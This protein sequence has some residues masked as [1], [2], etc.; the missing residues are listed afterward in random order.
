MKH[1]RAPKNIL[2]S[3]TNV[4]LKVT[5]QSLLL[6]CGLC[7]TGCAVARPADNAE[8]L[9][10]STMPS[11]SAHSPQMAMD[12]SQ[13]TYFKSVYGMGD[14]D[15]FMIL[16]SKAVPASS[17]RIVTGDTDGND[18]VTK[19]YVE[20]SSDP[21]ADM[22]SFKK[23]ATF[24]AQ[25][26]A[27]AKLRKAPIRAIRIKVNDGTSVP[28]LCIRE[29]SVTLPTKITHVQM[30]PGRAWSDYSATPDLAAWAHKAEHQMEDFWPDAT[31]LL[32]SKDFITPNTVNVIYRLG[33]DV[34]PVAATGG[35]VM[36]VNGDYARKSP[37]DS[38]LTV[39]EMAHVV[40][41]MSAYNPVW[42][43][44]GVADYI[45]WVRYE[46]QNFT[47]GIDPVKSSWRDPYR[48]S[49]AFLGWCEIH[50]NPRLVTLL[51]DDIRFGRYNDN[52]WKKY[53]G[54]D[55]DTLW[56]EFLADYKADPKGVLLPPVAPE[57]RPRALPTVTAGTSTPVSL[58]ALFTGK[59]FYTDGARFG[60]DSGFDEGG[61]AYPASAFGAGVTWKNV[62]FD[63]GKAGE[64]N[65]VSSQEQQVG[66]P[67]GQY[68]SLWLLAAAVEGNQKAQEF[69]VNYA[70]GSKQVLL[71]NVSDWFSPGN[72][73]GE[74]RAVKATYRNMGNGVKDTRTFY[75][76][77]YGFMLDKSKEVT[78]LTLPSNPNVKILAATVAN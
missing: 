43:I 54:K 53:T 20:T 32:Y 76:Y 19:G 41:S 72:F 37:N 73:P 3:C 45:R 55:G 47:Y 21:E 17:L 25:G 33:P 14:G 24:N 15:D 18:T 40:Q 49:A 26:V 44:E 13:S 65:I 42:L 69:V 12:G 28:T 39:H 59:G 70:D 64:S 30:G 4:K 23:V 38:G 61:A 46:P 50:Y 63:V 29:I 77:S 75:A 16:M 56:K 35:G 68:A 22:R 31:A 11:T 67:R 27:E 2:A 62:R 1:I 9:V 78:S 51:N 5:P 52:L 7:V 10:Y 66:L 58:A 71:Q 48:T 6:A 8:A 60:G 36:T 34:T 74:S 57:D